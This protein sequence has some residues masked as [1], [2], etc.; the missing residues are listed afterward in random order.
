MQRRSSVV[1]AVILS[2]LWGAPALA[3]GE[4]P[5]GAEAHTIHRY[6]EFAEAEVTIRSADGKVSIP[7]NLVNNHVVF[8]AAIQGTRLDVVLDTGMPMDGVMLYETDKV[9]R[10][11]LKYDE[12]ATA[13]IG[14]AGAGGGHVE[15][16]MAQG[17]TIDIGDLRITGATAI[18]APPLMAL[19]SYHDAVIGASL[20]K[21]LV[22][23]IDYDARRITLSAPG[24]W[25]PPEGS[26]AVPLTIEHGMPFADVTLIGGGGR[27]MP[28]P[29]VVDLGAAHPISLNLGAV[30]G[31]E[32]PAGAI[33]AVVGL[34]VSGRLQGRPHRRA[35][36]RRPSPQGR[37]R[38]VSRSRQPASGRDAGA[39]RQSRRRRPAALQRGVRLRA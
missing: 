19:A 32:A 3:E 36:D 16:R 24:S 34:G 23:A 30:D 26:V 13:R 37:G 11:A 14:G 6:V 25:A 20:F 9:S 22:V 31:L 4:A 33:H 1:T 15:A 7:F 18:V 2:S 28:T 5:A 39:R 8:Q 35:R 17:I 38:H 29:V 27:R 10:L 12:G 21:N